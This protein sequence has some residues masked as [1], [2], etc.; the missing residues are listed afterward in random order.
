[1][2][3]ALL[4]ARGLRRQR[5]RSPGAPLVTALDGVDLELEPGGSLAVVGPSGAGKSTLALSLARL[6]PLDAG[7]VWLEGH[8]LHALRG[9]ALRARRRRI[10]VVFQ[11]PA[12]S[13]NT[14]FRVED[15]VAEPMRIAGEPTAAR[16]DRALALLESV[17]LGMELGRRRPLELS[18]GQRQRVALARALA[19]E[20]RVLILDE[21]LASLDPSVA[22]QVAELVLALQDRTGVACLWITHD[23]RRAAGLA[24]HLAVLDAGRV[25]ESGPLEAV[26]RQPRHP[27]TR[28]LVAAEAEVA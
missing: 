11:D 24:R 7:E 22:A 13:L 26:L 12:A 19:A 16:R 23:L 3:E 14:R 20:P 25:V 21:A 2:P 4:L 28:A 6:E 8:P 9:E 18:G 17:G 10:Q 15:V 27:T 5:R 1:M